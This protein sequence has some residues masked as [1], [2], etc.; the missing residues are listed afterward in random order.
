[1]NKVEEA[2]TDDLTGFLPFTPIAHTG[3]DEFAGILTIE[4]IL[5]WQEEHPDAKLEGA[6]APL[7]VLDYDANPVVGIVEP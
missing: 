2:F 1:M 7:K 6:L 4:Q 5:K 3:K